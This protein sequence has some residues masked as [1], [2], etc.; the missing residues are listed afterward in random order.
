[1]AQYAGSGRC[2]ACHPAQFDT[3]STTGH[4][5][6]LALAPAGKPAHWAFGAGE[7]ATTYVSQVDSEWYV[8]HGLTYYAATK[9]MALTPGHSNDAGLRYRTFDPEGSV[10][11]CFRCHS[12]GAL[13]LEDKYEIQPSETGV[14]C[15]SC[16]GP[17]ADHADAPDRAAIRNPKKLNAVE[18]N[19]L[20]GSCHRKPP[21]AGEERDWANAWNVRHQPTYLSQSSC[22]RKSAGA[23]SCLTCHDPHQPL[24]RVSATYDRRCSTC[25]RTVRHKTAVTA[26]SCVDCHMPRVS[27]SP[28]LAFT[29]HWIGIYGKANKLIPARTRNAAPLVLPPSE[30]GGLPPPADPSSLRGLFESALAMREKET[31]AGDPRVARAASDYGLFL[32][33]I[34]DPAAAQSPLRRALEIDSTNNDPSLPADQENL[35]LVLEVAGQRA[36]AVE[37]LKLAAGGPDR[38]V[39]A[40]SLASLAVLEPSEAV[41]H[42]RDA[43]RA[44]EET[45]GKDHPR[46]AML[47]NNLALA[48]EERKEND[49]AVPLLRR[50]LAIQ[51]KS[52]GADHYETATT[53]NNLGSLLQTIGKLA[54]AEQLE[55]AALGIFE[56]KLPGTKE[57]SAACT[58]LADLLWTR[59]V[60]TSAV[61][62]YRRAI[63]IDESLYGLDHPEVAGDLTNL[64]LLLQESGDRVASDALLGRALAIYEKALGANSPQALDV[65]QSLSREPRRR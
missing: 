20:C 43:V 24:M 52:L 1:M 4:A 23:L 56:R 58:N 54:E 44:E 57:L 46:V 51:Q 64:G 65:R 26:R 27:T 12:T 36:Q 38:R 16:H 29:N 34:G 50:A 10:M 49:A 42:Y 63:S 41:P 62:L 13:K 33:A 21:E 22:F 37:L 39:A 6:A 11:R 31:T 14:R 9:S 35:A 18:L 17:G 59:G 28:Q 8:E 2:R 55:R 15:E 60:R 3:Q 7:K 53:M 48:L 19:E 40:R 45:S 32:K 30:A 5:R 47:F 61:G 25:H